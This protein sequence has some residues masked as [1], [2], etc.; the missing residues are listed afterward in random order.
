MAD[1]QHVSRAL[2]SRA[3]RDVSN[4]FYAH[5]NEYIRWP[6]TS[7]EKIANATKFYRHKI[8]KTPQRTP[9]VIGVVD[10][11]H[12]PIV[13]PTE[14]ES[15]FVNKSSYHSINTTVCSTFLSSPSPLLFHVMPLTSYSA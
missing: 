2:V 10:G 11:T 14:N 4:Y 15:C 3:V 1:T 7:A 13:K 12:V 5:R 9:R 8:K 6:K